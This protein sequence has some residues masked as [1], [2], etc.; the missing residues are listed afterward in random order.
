MK[1]AQLPDGEKIEAGEE[2]PP[3]AICPFCGGTVTLRRRKLMNNQG[4][5]FFWRH[6]DNENLQCQTRLRRR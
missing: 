3:K 4:F 5:S 1:T 2:A 6:L